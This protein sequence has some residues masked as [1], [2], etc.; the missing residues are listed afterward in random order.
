MNKVWMESEKQYIRDNANKKKD[1][2]LSKELT[3]MTGRVVSL[4][5]VRKQRQKMG[6]GKKPGRGVCGLVNDNN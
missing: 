1:V 2:E 3:K 6:L 4:Q 5:A